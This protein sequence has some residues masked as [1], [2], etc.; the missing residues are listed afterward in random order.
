MSDMKRMC[1]EA[2]HLRR[3]C[4]GVVFDEHIFLL[5]VAEHSLYVAH[6]EDL[7]LRNTASTPG[8]RP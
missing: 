4:C 3:T 2:Q 8:C 6:E 5:V 7:S 1:G